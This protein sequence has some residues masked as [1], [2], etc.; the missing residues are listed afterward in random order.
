MDLAL[1]FSLFFTN[2]ANF[3]YKFAYYSSEF[4]VFRNFFHEIIANYGKMKE[5]MK[6]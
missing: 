2:S 4:F 5:I 3:S 6:I 1:S